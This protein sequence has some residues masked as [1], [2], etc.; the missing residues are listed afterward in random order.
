MQSMRRLPSSSLASGFV[1]ALALSITAFVGPA[2][3]DTGGPPPQGYNADGTPAAPQGQV[4]LPPAP[5]ADPGAVDPNA[6]DPNAPNPA[7]PDEFSDTDPSALTD[8]REPLAPYGQWTEDANYGTIWVPNADQ[9]GADFAPYQ[10]AGSWGVNGDG[11]W[12]WQSDYS[13]GAIPFH[14]GRWVWA[15]SNWGWIPGRRYAPAW[16]SWRVGEGGYLGWAPRPPSYYWGRGRALALGRAPYAAYCFVPTNYA[17][18]RN[19]SSYV[20]RDRGQIQSIAAG[21][22]AYH[23]ATPTVDARGAG[24]YNAHGPSLS[25]AHIPASASPRGRPASDA[26]GMS[27]ATRSATA[28]TFAAS[29]RSYANHASQAG[30]GQVTQT[31]RGNGG[32]Y[33][34][35]GG[36]SSVTRSSAQTYQHAT[37]P[38]SPGLRTP[39][40]GAGNAGSFHS[41]YHPYQGSQHVQGSTVH[42]QS[43]SGSSSS[44][45]HSHVSAGRSGGGRH[46]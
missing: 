15:G 28:S 2:L 41:A 11:D 46:R 9:V 6:V 17:F 3:A 32:G 29:G 20:V 24:S 10:S 43:S 4:L 30:G 27:Y 8:F 40:Y 38:Q 1:A 18:Y 34:G 16:V 23:P 25:E 22:R 5:D 19:V 7:N 42:P 39:G 35:G 45:S 14:Y 12:L 13:W 37:R 31:Y 26:R 33:G 44:V 36:Y 21:T